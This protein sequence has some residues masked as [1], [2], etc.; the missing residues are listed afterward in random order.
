LYGLYKEIIEA[1]RVHH[2]L[3]VPSPQRA[4]AIRL[5]FAASCLDQGQSV[6]RTPVVLSE[7]D[8]LD[9][10]LL[11]ASDAGEIMPRPLRAAEEWCVWREACAEALG[12]NDAA[13]AD[14]LSDALRDSARLLFAWGISSDV[15]RGAGAES[16]LLERTLAGVERRCLDLNA[17]ATHER[18]QLLRRRLWREGA[19]RAHITLAGFTEQ[20]PAR[21]ALTH[22]WSQQGVTLRASE[23]DVVLG[24]ASRLEAPDALAEL[25]LAADWCRAQL[26]EDAQRRLLVVIPD[27]SR[28]AATIERVFEDALSAAHV[29]SGAGQGKGAIIEGG[30]ALGGYPLVQQ[31][32]GTL[33][34]LCGSVPFDAMS[35]WLRDA[36]W[37]APGPAERA[38]LDLWLRGSLSVEVDAASLVAA[39]RTA[40]AGLSVAASL[41]ARSLS[42]ASQRLGPLTASM[43][44]RVWYQRFQHALLATGWPGARPL[45]SEEEQTR[46]RFAEVLEE[47]AALA[48]RF[49]PVSPARALGILR[50][51]SERALFAPATGDAAVTLSAALVD[52]I[53]RYDGI[54]VAGMHADA[55]PPPPRLDPF[56]PAAAQRR[57]GITGAN[58]EQLLAH[59]HVLLERWRRAAPQLV[60]S[61]P[62]HTEDREQPISPLLA[63]LP[64][65]SGAPAPRVI[66][67]AQCVRTARRSERYPDRL[68]TPWAA[69]VLPAG[70]RL[71][72]QQS[73]CAFRAYAELRLASASMETPRPGIDPRARGRFIHRALELLWQRL[74]NARNLH[75]AHAAGQLDGWIEQSAVRALEQLTAA[76]TLRAD[77]PNLARELRRTVRLVRQLCE[78][79]LTRAPFMVHALEAR[80]TLMLAGAQLE[81]RIDRIDELD[82]GTFAVFDYKT[83]RPTQLGWSDERMAQPQLPVYLRAAKL[84][85]SA[86]AAVYVSSQQSGY[87]G[88]ADRIGRLPRVN[89]LVETP[90]PE[91]VRTW[92]ERIEQLAS[93][94]ISGH[95]AAEP[96]AQACQICHLHAF[97]RIADR[98]ERET[99]DPAR[100]SADE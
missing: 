37:S 28:R 46:A 27:L 88:L 45:S 33:A 82:D 83:G 67:L 61:S 96:I 13:L 32:L 76:R 94:F 24:A 90:W 97:C 73:R 14:S 26:Q 29:L 85:V 51:L 40:P 95:A 35:A 53:V 42:A 68:G 9:R 36:F 1:L 38:R 78:L 7:S 21:R 69:Q 25:E 31:A 34:L 72:E 4:A 84:D 47:G 18:Y 56:I 93:D 99:P 60:L 48:P 12:E 5:A 23:S 89:A 63:T 77:Q 22:A 3:V 66:S 30:K 52:P 92:G 43:S 54:W 10:E 59:T 44:T 49:G 8:W 16:E 11:R 65:W 64:A 57:A 6:W 17:A 100:G 39:L 15:L 70:A 50:S 71:I 87:R 86:V 62:Q 74:A 19:A 80:R 20:I 58:A 41:I 98:T 75:E 81:V 2:T 55:W 79:E 91:Q